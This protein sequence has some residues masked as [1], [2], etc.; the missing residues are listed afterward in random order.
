[1]GIVVAVDFWKS[2]QIQDGTLAGYSMMLVA[3]SLGLGTCQVNRSVNE[4]EIKEILDIPREKQVICALVPGYPT[5]Y[6]TTERGGL[7]GMVFREKW[8]K[9]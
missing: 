6:P 5:E 8:G 1:M 9:R 7:K 4:S 3:D 2:R